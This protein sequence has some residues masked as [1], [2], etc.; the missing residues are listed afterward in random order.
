VEIKLNQI[1]LDGTTLEELIPC[2]DLELET[3]VIK[4]RDPIQVKAC[5]FRITNAVSV[6]LDLRGA[7]YTQCSRCLAEIKIDLRRNVSLHYQVNLV[8]RVIPLNQDIRAE[9]I[10]D[11]PIKPLC[12]TDC[13]GICSKCGTDLN[14]QECECNKNKKMN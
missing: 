1:P 7:F 6:D 12:K 10:M 14:E 5:V 8:D 4:F 3:D 2:Q 11:Y 13:R 9:I